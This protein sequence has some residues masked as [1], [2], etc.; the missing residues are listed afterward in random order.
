MFLYVIEKVFSKSFPYHS[1]PFYF[2]TDENSVL[3][4][5]EKKIINES[6]LLNDKN[7]KETQKKM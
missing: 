3:I 4:I 2:R 7:V 1:S 5:K 6:T